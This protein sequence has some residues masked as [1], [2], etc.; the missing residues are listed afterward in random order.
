MMTLRYMEYQAPEAGVGNTIFLLQV[1]T[2][3][4]KIEHE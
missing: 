2:D 1:G 4:K 3:S